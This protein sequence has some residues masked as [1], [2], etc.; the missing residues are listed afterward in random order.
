[1]H[2]AHCRFSTAILLQR[3]NIILG[4]C[5]DLPVFLRENIEAQPNT[6]ARATTKMRANEGSTQHA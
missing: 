2:G 1:M 3:G 4:V 5:R 6:Q